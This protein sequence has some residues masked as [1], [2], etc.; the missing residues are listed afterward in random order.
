MENK[1][2]IQQSEVV[3]DEQEQVQAPAQDSLTNSDNTESTQETTPPSQPPHGRWVPINPSEL[4]F[5][6]SGE[7]DRPI[8][9]P[10][11]HIYCIGNSQPTLAPVNPSTNAIP[12]PSAIIQMPSIVQP[13]SLV[14]YTSQNQPML[15]YDP[16]SRP[17]PP[18]APQDAP[19]Y[20]KKPYKGLS[21]A[22]MVIALLAIVLPLLFN[23]ATGIYTSNGLDLVKASLI[24]FGA[25]DLSSSYYNE[26]IAP[27]GNI[28]QAIVDAPYDNL[29]I[30]ALP[31]I[32][33]LVL[34]FAFILVIKYL[35]K[36]AKSQSPRGFSVLAFGNILLGLSAISI[37]Y[38]MSAYAD[39]TTEPIDFLMGQNAIGLGLGIFLVLILNLVLLVLPF[40]AKKY[41]HI[42]DM[43][44]ASRTYFFPPN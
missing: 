25:S 9:G 26:A 37:L 43:P 7:R 44:S 16:Y 13:I 3:K 15:Q 29:A 19:R 38:G 40:G 21:L 28:V 6:V 33:T 23:I 4:D 11:G 36:L 20:K 30:L 1:N 10:D 18:E 42:L 31:I 12:R 27:L 34:L 5:A 41:A 24:V 35:V 14:P 2:N 22:L 17:L 39:K 32:F 8:Q